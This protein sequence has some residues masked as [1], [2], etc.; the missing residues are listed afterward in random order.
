VGVSD[1]VWRGRRVLLTGHTGFKGGWLALWLARLGARVTGI[2]LP[3]SPSPN[4]FELARVA[5]GIDSRFCDI[6][7]AAGLAALVE[8]AQPEIVFHLAAQ[9]LV[10]RSYA[11]PLETYATNVMGT[12]HLLEAIRLKS[13]ATRAIV[14]VTTDKCYEN[15]EWVWGYRESDPLG[16]H[17]PYSSSKAGTELVAASYAKSFFGAPGM[18]AL[19]T[20]RAGNV[21]GGGDWAADR[22]V[23]DL[24]RACQTGQTVA[25]RYP[26]AIRPWQHVLE[27]LAGYLRLAERLYE[28]GR[29]YAGAWNFGPGQESLK[30]VA[31]IAE[32]VIAAWGGSAHWEVP[33]GAEPHEAGILKLDCSK[34]AQYLDWHP[35]LDIG[36]AIGLTVQWHKACIAGQDMRKFTEAQIGAHVSD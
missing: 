22:L 11:D 31:W 10:R 29:Q 21:I 3:P 15:R 17:D 25:I 2:S 23:P 9:P 19:A 12:A 14:V 36:D 27:P 30:P 32:R 24:V 34:A 4:L 33:A 6:R 7:D 18:P 8:Q 20:A 1:S 35:A 26:Q 16:G 13:P 5:E 28:H